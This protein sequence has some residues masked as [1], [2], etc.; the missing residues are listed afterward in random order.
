MSIKSQEMKR[1]EFAFNYITN[2]VENIEAQKCFKSYVKNVPSYIKTNGLIETYA[3]IGMKK[4]N[5]EKE[6]LA[7]QYIYDLTNDWLMNEECSVKAIYNRE[8]VQAENGLMKKFLQLSS[9][10]YKLITKEI[11]ALFSWARRFAESELKG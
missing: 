1:A 11:L 3:F 8:D 7:Y 9:E 4:G 6:E 5:V 2:K 10:D